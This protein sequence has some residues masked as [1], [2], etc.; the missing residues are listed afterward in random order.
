MKK[1]VAPSWLRWSNERELG[2]CVLACVCW[3]NAVIDGCVAA[4]VRRV[5]VS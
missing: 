1:C 2:V 4:D 5:A 3:V